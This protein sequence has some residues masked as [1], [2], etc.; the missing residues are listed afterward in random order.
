[1]LHVTATQVVT[2]AA[3]TKDSDKLVMV[4]LVNVVTLM[5]VT[6]LT[7]HTTVTK[8]LPVVISSEAMN[9]NVR[10]VAHKMLTHTPVVPTQN[11]SISKVHMTVNVHHHFILL[12]AS[13]LMTRNVLTITTIVTEVDL[14][15]LMKLWHTQWNGSV[16]L[17]HTQ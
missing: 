3:V 14:S 5:N 4:I 6:L 1:M 16:V 13:V 11:V 15:V 12:K 2:H 8:M 10:P 17:L 7:Q 9:V